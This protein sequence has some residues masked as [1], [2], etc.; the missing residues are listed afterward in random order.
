M[1]NVA[2]EESGLCR[3]PGQAPALKGG[4]T[5]HVTQTQVCRFQAQRDPGAQTASV[6]SD[7][8]IPV[9][10]TAVLHVSPS[11]LSPSIRPCAARSLHPSP[12]LERA[13]GPL[14]RGVPAE[15]IRLPGGRAGRRCTARARGT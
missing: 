13:V 8:F 12:A 5:V 3:C 6:L 9:L 1:G 4:F 2:V 7:G 14:L 15:P 11:R 10:E